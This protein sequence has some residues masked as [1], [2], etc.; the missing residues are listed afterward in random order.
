MLARL[1]V[2]DIFWVFF[3]P[4]MVSVAKSF[5]AHIKLLFPTADSARPFSMLGLGD[6]VIPVL[7]DFTL[8]LWMYFCSTSIK[9][10]VS[11]GKQ[12]QYFKSA[13]LGYTVGLVLIIVVMN[14]FQAAQPALLYIVPSVIGFLAT[15]CIWNGEVKPLLEFDE[16]KTAAT[17]QEEAYDA[18]GPTG[19]ITIKW[20]VI[21]CTLDGYVAVVT[22]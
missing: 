19:N 22:M 21:S 18:L 1:F 16:S 10:D 14:W 15:H 5:D 3:T 12:S 6:F 8:P 20:D 13:F 9:I 11:R 2:Y 17:S 7:Y 4:V